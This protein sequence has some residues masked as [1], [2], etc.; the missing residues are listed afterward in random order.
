MSEVI[1]EGAQC[2]CIFGSGKCPLSVTNNMTNKIKGKKIATIMDFTPGV[3]IASFGTCT[4]PANPAYVASQS[5]GG[6]P[7]PCMPAIMTPWSPG[8]IKTRLKTIPALLAISKATCTLAA[9]P[10]SISLVQANQQDMTTK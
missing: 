5:A 4:S 7:P 8:A 2:Q 1:V 10:M 9:A 3:N 6:P